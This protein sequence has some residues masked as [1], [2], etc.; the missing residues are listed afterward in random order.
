MNGYVSPYGKV[1]GLTRRLAEF[2]QRLRTDR[3]YPWLG[4]GIIA[5]LE[6][7]VAIL[8]LREFGEYLRVHGTDSRWGNEILELLEKS[9]GDDETIE[10]FETAIECPANK[11]VV[12][13]AENLKGEVDA[14]RKVLVE[15]GA[16]AE[17][18]DQTPIPDL[19]RMLLS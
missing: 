5:D 10:A 1:A 3:S 12:R 7:I 2:A 18:D 6:A 17:G 14:V 15:T 4:T 11:D 19:L 8:N 13:H 16:L 9:E